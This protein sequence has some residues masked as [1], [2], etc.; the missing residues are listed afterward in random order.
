MKR[1][2]KAQVKVSHVHEL[3]CGGMHIIMNLN[4]W[5]ETNSACCVRSSSARGCSASQSSEDTLRG[6]LNLKDV[7]I[8]CPRPAPPWLG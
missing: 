4:V 2:I 6:V 1:C 5:L 8:G 7:L 3:R